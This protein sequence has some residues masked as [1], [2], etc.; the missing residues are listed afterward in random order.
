[1]LMGK[2][3]LQ[4][5]KGQQGPKGLR[6][7][8]DQLELTVKT[9]QSELQDQADP[10]DTQGHKV[11]LVQMDKTVCYQMGLMLGTQLTGTELSGL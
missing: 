10:Q 5:H 3:E 11:L 7:S 2:T 6:V 8:K 9:A 4:G 1:M